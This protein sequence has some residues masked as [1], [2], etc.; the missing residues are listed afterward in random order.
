MINLFYSDHGDISTDITLGMG[1][2]LTVMI[3]LFYSDHGDIST[4]ITLGM[5]GTAHCYD[6]PVLFRSWRYFYRH[7]SRNG[8]DCSLL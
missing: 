7:N 1:G 8:R 5:G 3:N 6:Q 2:L 4:D